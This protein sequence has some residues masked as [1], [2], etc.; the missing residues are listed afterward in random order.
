MNGEVPNMDVP[1]VFII[2]YVPF[3]CLTYF[4]SKRNGYRIYLIVA[5]VVSIIIGVCSLLFLSD[6]STIKWVRC[7]F[8]SIPMVCFFQ[9]DKGK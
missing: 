2:I 3:V 6:E 4:F 1:V 8:W 7:V 9:L 5:I